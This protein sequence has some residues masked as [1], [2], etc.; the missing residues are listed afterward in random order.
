MWCVG[1][2]VCYRVVV[3]CALEAEL[4]PQNGALWCAIIVD[5]DERCVATN[6]NNIRT[7]HTPTQ[8]QISIYTAFA[9]FCSES[10]KFIQFLFAADSTSLRKWN[11]IEPP[12]INPTTVHMST[13]Q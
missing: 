9:A 8:V 7:T 5:L 11:K 4:C 6:N 2:A 1:V 12:T 13:K 3:L 10:S